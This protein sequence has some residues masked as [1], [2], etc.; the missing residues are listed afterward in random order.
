M[1]IH[2]TSF[3]RLACLFTAHVQS[4]SSP[5]SCGVFLPPLFLQAFLLLIAGHV[6]LLL[7]AGVFV[8]SSRGKVSLP[9]LWSFPPSTTFTNFPVPGCWVYATFLPSPAQLVYL[10]FCEGFSSLPLR[11]SGHPTL[12]ATSLYC[13]YCLLLSFSFFPCMGIG[14]SRGLF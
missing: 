8:Y 5:L 13:C 4:G 10:Q 12:F 7:L 6:L 9:L 14:L 2:S 3:L 11:H 1:R